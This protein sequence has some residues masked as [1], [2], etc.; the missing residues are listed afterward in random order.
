MLD[1]DSERET[2]YSEK[3]Y[4]TDDDRDSSVT[5]TIWQILRG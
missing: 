3:N 5:K 1:N 2:S 4:V